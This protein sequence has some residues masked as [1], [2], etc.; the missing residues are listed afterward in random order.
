MLN[1]VAE[2]EIVWKPACG[3]DAIF[4]EEYVG[5]VVEIDL[6]VSAVADKGWDYVEYELRFVD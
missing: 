1:T 5:A 4:G 3:L 2:E 6:V